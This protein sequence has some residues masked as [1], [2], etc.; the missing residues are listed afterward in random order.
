MKTI[1]K[2]KVE[3]YKRSES[4][5]SQGTLTSEDLGLKSRFN[6]TRSASR[7]GMK[8]K[9]RVV[10]GKKYNTLQEEDTIL[11]SESPRNRDKFY[12]HARNGSA[13]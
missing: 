13:K 3:Q 5:A 11:E 9:D 2:K 6:K 12:K 7:S 1:K 4:R 8:H 10:Y